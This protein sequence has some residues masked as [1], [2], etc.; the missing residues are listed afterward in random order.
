MHPNARLI[1]QFYE[2]FDAHDARVMAAAYAD[3]ATFSDPVFPGLD[4]DGV[5]DMWTMLCEAEDLTVEVSQ[6]EADDDSGTARWDACYT[7]V[8]TGRKVHNIIH[9]EFEFEDG[10]IS[11]HT[12]HFDFWR[13]SRHA[14]GAP[15]V[16]LGWTPFLKKKVQKMAGG[17][18]ESWRAKR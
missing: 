10:R 7:F 5:R 14:L 16:L 18:L 2:A 8:A 1:T 12:D 11:K 3:D 15:G 6:V 4:A 9:A 13:W 17:R